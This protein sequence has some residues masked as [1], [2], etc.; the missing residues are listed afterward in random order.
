[1]SKAA[2]LFRRSQ[3]CYR[4]ERLSFCPQWGGGGMPPGPP[5]ADPPERHPLPPTATAADGTHP[6]GMLS[7]L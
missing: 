1:M 7:C 2:N 4:H 3:C 5:W 6:S